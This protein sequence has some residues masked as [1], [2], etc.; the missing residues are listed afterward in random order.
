MLVSLGEETESIACLIETVGLL[1]AFAV[2]VCLRIAL[3]DSQLPHRLF[4]LE[5][6][7]LSFF[8]GILISLSSACSLGIPASFFS[9]WFGLV[10]ICFSRAEISVSNT[11]HNLFL[12]PSLENSI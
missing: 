7:L 6:R 9:W 2:V 8:T 5:T 12:Y 4:L 11:S 3:T 10:E 1:S